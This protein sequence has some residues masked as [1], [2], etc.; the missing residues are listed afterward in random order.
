MFL[1]NQVLLIAIITIKFKW[2]NCTI[3]SNEQALQLKMIF[4]RLTLFL[5]IDSRSMCMAAFRVNTKADVISSCSTEAEL[6]SLVLP[7]IFGVT[8]LSC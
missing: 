7:N 5:E 2:Q 3:M 6:T 8:T 1:A 4:V